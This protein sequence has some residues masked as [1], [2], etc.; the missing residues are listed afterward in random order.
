MLG[1]EP[2]LRVG[3]A[4][5][6]SGLVLGGP[7]AGDLVVAD[8]ARGQPLGTIPPGERWRIEPDGSA[9]RLLKPDGSSDVRAE[10]FAV[11]NASE[12]QFAVVSN[13]RYRGSF[14]LFRDRTGVTLV[15]RVGLEGYLRSVVGGEMGRRPD[16]DYQ[17]VLAQAIVSRT[18]AWRNRGRWQSQGFDVYGDTRDQAYAGVETEWPVGMEA[19]T[20]TAGMGLTYRGEAIEG[21]YH[22]TCGFA[23]AAVEEAFTT[24]RSRPYLRSVSD[25]I[26]GDRYYC[27]I[28][29]RFRWREEWDGAALAR[30]LSDTAP[31]VTGIEAGRF[32]AIRD[33]R[34]AKTGPSGRVAEL[35]VELD[36]VTA[37]IPGPQ[38]R[39]VLKPAPD[40]WLGSTAFQLQVTKDRGLVTRVAAAGGGW[41]HGVGLCQWGAVGR[42]RAGQGYEDILDHYFP[43]TT[44][45]KLY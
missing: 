2:E 38:V 22:S 18:F 26:S 43:G 6:A 24:V 45:A 12:G 20:R 35:E 13:R 14:Q 39:V 5:G 41:G 1:A 37:R 42:A 31:A 15:N 23:T 32:A 16:T 7:G 25:R 21:Y 8:E 11:V 9:L 40:R 30:I 17:A 27:G 44:I 33:L 19:V 36:Q 3:L 4:V 10:R 28:S 34:V 29:P